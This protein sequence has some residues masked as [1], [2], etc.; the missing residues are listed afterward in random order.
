MET[1]GVSCRSVSRARDFRA[2]FTGSPDS[3]VM[4]ERQGA[5]R[6]R[7]EA[8]AWSFGGCWPSAAALPASSTVASAT[9]SDVLFRLPKRADNLAFSAEGEDNRPYFPGQ[10]LVSV[11]SNASVLICP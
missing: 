6:C 3:E 4:L 8:I 11:R 10:D 1:C 9:T 7:F 2:F 5:I